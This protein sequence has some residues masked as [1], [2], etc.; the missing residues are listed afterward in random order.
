MHARSQIR[1]EVQSTVYCSYCPFRLRLNIAWLRARAG[2]NFKIIIKCKTEMS[3]EPAPYSVDLR[4]RIIWQRFGMEL[5]FRSTAMNLNISIGTAYNTNVYARHPENW[6]L[7]SKSIRFVSLWRAPNYNNMFTDSRSQ[8]VSWL[9]LSESTNVTSIWVSSSTVLC[10]IIYRHAFTQKIIQQVALQRSIAYIGDFMAEMHFYTVEQMDETGCD[11][12]D[13]IRQFGYAMK[14][15]QPS[16]LSSIFC[17]EGKNISCVS[18]VYNR[19]DCTRG[20]WRYFE[21]RK[22][23]WFYCRYFLIPAMSQFDGS[24]PRSVLVM[25]NCSIHHVTPAQQLYSWNIMHFPS[26][27]QPPQWGNI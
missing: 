11:K 10:H 25:D 27:L 21:W 19:S 14:G 22:V 24:S 7:T 13:H 20:T 15:E 3:C 17:I 16:V 18:Y 8:H 1:R 26:T 5:R 12:R 9:S 4:H 6:E 23:Y 2:G